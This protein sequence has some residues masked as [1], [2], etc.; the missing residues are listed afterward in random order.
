MA[1]TY[2]PANLGKR[3]VASKVVDHE[4]VAVIDAVTA[5]AL[6]PFTVVLAVIGAVVSVML[7][8]GTFNPATATPHTAAVSSVIVWIAC[9]IAPAFS[10]VFAL[11]SLRHGGTRTTHAMALSALTVALA[12]LALLLSTQLL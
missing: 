7:T 8:G 3:R 1:I 2:S 12:F 10:I 9:A 11:E 5:L 6:L 4:R